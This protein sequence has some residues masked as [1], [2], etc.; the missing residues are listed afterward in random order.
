[1]CHQV[2]VRILGLTV[3]HCRPVM[4]R[5]Q[6]GYASPMEALRLADNERINARRRMRRLWKTIHAR[7]YSHL[8]GRS[9]V[10]CHPE[11][12]AKRGIVST[13]GAQGKLFPATGMPD[14]DWWTVLWPRPDNVVV[15]LGMTPGMAVVDLCCGDG[16]F[17]VPMASMA[18]EVFAI[19]LDPKMLDLTSRRLS[20]TE[21]AK[22]KLVVGDA[23]NMDKLVGCHV[24]FVLMANTYHGVPD[25]ARLGK[26]VFATLK[27]GGLFAVVNWHRHPREETTVLDQPRGPKTELRMT[28]EDVAKSLAPSGLIPKEVVELP[29]YHYGAVFV[30]PSN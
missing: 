3:R 22:T 4:R 8:G 5:A 7:A 24:D 18:D 6:S 19:D 12:W 20:G 28:P 16:L 29:P 23:Y 13:N 10:A 30:K 9:C 15:L 14:P 21:A 25:K 1:M 2:Y 27:Q 11:V 26:A 17:T